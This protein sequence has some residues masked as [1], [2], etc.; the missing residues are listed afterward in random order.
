MKNNFYAHSLEGEPP[1]KWQK[2]EAH[3]C[4]TAE[5]AGKFAAKFDAAE[6]GY[7]AGLWHDIGKY[8][9]EFQAYIR[10]PNKVDDEA[11]DD[12]G[13]GRV[14]HSSAGAWCAFESSGTLA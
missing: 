9:P 5:L 1:E 8:L 14:N 10:G 2:L 12:I 13:P 3:L 6:W 7:L 4:Q 11:Y